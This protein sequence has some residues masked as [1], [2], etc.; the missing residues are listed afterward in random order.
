MTNVCY[1]GPENKTL[2]ITE[3]DTGSILTCEMPV[4]GKVLYSHM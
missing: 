1:G 3:A 4:P 2:F